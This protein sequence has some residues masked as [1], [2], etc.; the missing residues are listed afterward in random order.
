[1]I[2]NVVHKIIILC[3]YTIMIINLVNNTNVTS[4]YAIHFSPG[5]PKRL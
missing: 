4:R 2:V 3:I 1:M 5:I